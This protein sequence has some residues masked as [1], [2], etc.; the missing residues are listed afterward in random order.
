MTFGGAATLLQTALADAAGDYADVALS[1][2][3]VTWN[4]AIALGGVTG[5]L[6]LQHAGS[7]SFPWAILIL[8]LVALATAACAKRGFPAVNSRAKT[9]LNP[10]SE[11]DR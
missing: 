9:A 10:A 4:S 6:L 1:M 8:L 11:I 3:V 5:G 7:Q 2:N